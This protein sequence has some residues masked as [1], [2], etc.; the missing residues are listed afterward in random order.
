MPKKN[1]QKPKRET[2][3][4]RLASTRPFLDG[5]DSYVDE[6]ERWK[7]MD[8]VRG[9]LGVFELE[10]SDYHEKETKD[11]LPL[12][13]FCSHEQLFYGVEVA[14]TGGLHKET[15]TAG[16]W[17]SAVKD[18]FGRIHPIIFVRR[19]VPSHPDDEE[20]PSEES[21]TAHKLLVL[22]HEMGH[23]DDIRKSVNYT[24]DSLELGI[25]EA[26]LYSHDFVVR[27]CRKL[28]Y[29]LM[30]SEYLRNIENQRTS[31]NEAARIAAERFAATNDIAEIQR[32]CVVDD[33]IIKFSLQKSGRIKEFQHRYPG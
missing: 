25:V 27:H 2:D 16:G 26:E 5:F 30:L 11:L 17:T 14:N 20:V 1:K 29:R 33:H 19:D 12:L 32:F 10:D 15:S 6:Y 24:H 9:L 31:K 21:T 18:Q 13:G 22:I 23:A 7:R 28:G 4:Q 8:V 3:I